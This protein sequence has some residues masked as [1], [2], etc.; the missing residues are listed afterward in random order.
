MF[1]VVKHSR[2]N[3]ALI[4]TPHAFGSPPRCARR[5]S[6]TQISEGD[7]NLFNKGVLSSALRREGNKTDLDGNNHSERRLMSG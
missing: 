3:L 1:K 5:G 2:R 7:V 4:P 6:K